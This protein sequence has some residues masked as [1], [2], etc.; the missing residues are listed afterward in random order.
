LI[1]V[2]SL[3]GL[4]PICLAVVATCAA[5]CGAI[6][7]NGAGPGAPASPPTAT[8]SPAGSAATAQQTAEAIKAAVPEV[9]SLIAI[10]EDNDRNNLIGRTNGYVAATVAVDSRIAEG[11]DSAKPGIKCGA[12]IEQWPGTAAAKS[13]ADYLKAVES[14]LPIAGSEYDTLQG[15]LLLRVSGKLKPSAA[16][17]YQAAFTG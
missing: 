13:R 11:C 14:K 17:A 9:T 6:S 5:A 3:T 10:T 15:N 8:A 7:N 1:S 16:Q 2:T 12:T 4:K